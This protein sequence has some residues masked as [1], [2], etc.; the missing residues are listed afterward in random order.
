MRAV[1]IATGDSPEIKPLDD[2]HPV[3]LLPLVDRPFIQHVVEFFAGQGATRFDFVLS[4]LPEKIEHQ[5]GD[6]AR[7]GSRFTFHLARD[8]RCPYRVLKA[9]DWSG[10]DAPL[11]FGHADRLPLV[12]LGE[13][14][15]RPAK[16]VLFCW[17]GTRR[18]AADP[19]SGPRRLWTGWALLAPEHLT[20]L[21]ADAD[22]DGLRQHLV[23]ASRGEPAW[24]EVP[25]P[26]AVRTFEEVLAS[27]RAVLGKTAPGLLLSCREAEPGVWLSRNVQLHPSVRF[28][29]PVFV[30]E[31][32]DIGPGVQLGPYAAVGSDSVL[33]AHCTVTNS[34]IFSGSYVG[35]G[36]ALAD[37][38]VDKNRL[39]NVRLG[40]AVVLSEDFILGSLSERHLARWLT[41]MLSRAAAVTALLAAAPV[42]LA[43]AL[44]LKLFRGGPVVYRKEAIRLP[45]GEEDDWKTFTV[46]SFS[47]PGE[48]P[49]AWGRDLDT[50]RGLLLRFLPALVSAVRG[51]LALVGLPPRSPEEVRRLSPDWRTLYLS[52][53]AGIVTEASVRS[54]ADLSEDE[55]YAADAFYV[56]TAGWRYDLKLLAR[57]LSRCLL[58]PLL[59]R[60]LP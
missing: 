37:V 54:P 53:K 8:P 2:R 19:S 56:V 60:R 20:T 59:P 24:F 38:I 41:G 14:A 28:F 40:G 33:D 27:H 21:P 43:T 55:V 44:Y 3:P 1:I 7:W 11:L 16:P 25:P 36:L 4:H 39:V 30:G 9:L 47:P 26:L 13:A 6:G 29:P 5:L 22:E 52:T 58:G 34:V 17:P 10:D 51:D 15:A 23:K 57:Y 42:L 35:E 32:C 48:G 49:G 46:W 18:V 31:N 12:P 45:A 50:F